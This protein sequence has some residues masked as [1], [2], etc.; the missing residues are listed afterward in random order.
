[1]AYS[2][3][4]GRCQFIQYNRSATLLTYK[5][6][7]VNIVVYAMHV[8]NVKGR[9]LVCSEPLSLMGKVVMEI[10]NPH[11]ELVYSRHVSAGNPQYPYSHQPSL[12]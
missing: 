12:Y 3:H 8:A 6:K 2:H 1:M 7:Q 9:V 4:Q 11:F 10:L 5:Y